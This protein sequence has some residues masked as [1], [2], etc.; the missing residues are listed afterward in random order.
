MTT[1]THRKTAVPSRSRSIRTAVAFAASIA[2]G[3]TAPSAL[4]TPVVD[5]WITQEG[6]ISNIG[7]VT[8]VF[9]PNTATNRHIIQ[10]LSMNIGM[11]NLIFLIMV[12]VG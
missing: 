12:M 1:Q 2:L 9:L 3:A 10:W 11:M 8:N 5:Q 6:V 4:A 7:S